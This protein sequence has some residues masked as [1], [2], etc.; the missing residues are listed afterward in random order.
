[1]TEADSLELIKNGESTTVEF[2]QSTNEI[3]GMRHE[4]A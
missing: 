4:T 1:M 3:I 2:K